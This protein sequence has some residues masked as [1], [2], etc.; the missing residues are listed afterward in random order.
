[1]NLIDE[2][3]FLLL[4]EMEIVQNLETKKLSSKN[5]KIIFDKISVNNF[6]QVY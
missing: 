1:M 6:T 2:F 4:H 3:S 5:S